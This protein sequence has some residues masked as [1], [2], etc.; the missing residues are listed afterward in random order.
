MSDLNPVLQL[1][2]S[3]TADRLR[4]TV[5]RA[6]EFRG[7][8]Y[9]SK[10][11]NAMHIRSSS[12]RLGVPFPVGRSM[13]AWEAYLNNRFCTLRGWIQEVKGSEEPDPGRL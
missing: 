1:R 4:K 10:V 6:D 9:L 2:F 13:E 5:E 12:S 7:S 3:S 11:G 8:R